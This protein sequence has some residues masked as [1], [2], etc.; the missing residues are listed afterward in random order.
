MKYFSFS[1]EI[2]PKIDGFV[3]KHLETYIENN[4]SDVDQSAFANYALSR[5]EDDLDHWLNVGW[6]SLYGQFLAKQYP[7]KG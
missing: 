3:L 1:Q 2:T 4:I 5:L 7:S 6:A